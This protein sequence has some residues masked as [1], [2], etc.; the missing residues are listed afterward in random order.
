MYERF[1]FASEIER[2]AARETLSEAFPLAKIWYVSDPEDTDFLMDA[3]IPVTTET[4]FQYAIHTPGPARLLIFSCYNLSMQMLNPPVWME[5][6]LRKLH[7]Q[8]P[9]PNQ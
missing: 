6:E 7:R 2:S 5:F 9:A 8:L 3:E 4:F 1:I